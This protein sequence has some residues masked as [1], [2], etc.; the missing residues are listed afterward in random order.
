MRQVSCKKPRT[1]LNSPSIISYSHE[2]KLSKCPSGNNP[3][4]NGDRYLLKDFTIFKMGVLF[5]KLLSRVS[6]IP[7]VRIWLIT[8]SS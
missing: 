8:L 4:G 6:P 7:L 2:N 3:A 5:L 1:Y